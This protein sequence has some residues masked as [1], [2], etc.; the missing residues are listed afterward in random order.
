M[1]TEVEVRWKH[2]GWD[3]D[4]EVIIIKKLMEWVRG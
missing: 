4:L 3:T 1:D 2:V